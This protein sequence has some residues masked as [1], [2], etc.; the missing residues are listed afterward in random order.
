[1]IP[2][3]GSGRFCRS[4]VGGNSEPSAYSFLLWVRHR[5]NLSL[6]TTWSCVGLCARRCSV[7]CVQCGRRA[8]TLGT[9]GAPHP[10][11][12]TCPM[13]IP[14]LSLVTLKFIRNPGSVFGVFQSHSQL[15][16]STDHRIPFFVLF[17]VNF[18]WYRCRANRN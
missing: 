8:A 6:R 15:S 11:I 10:K 5:T 3:Q 2:C 9:P 13:T 1:M 12:L 4:M 16:D 18:L 17:V 7:S 14:L